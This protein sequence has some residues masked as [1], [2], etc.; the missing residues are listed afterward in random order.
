MA[1]K[2]AK[3]GFIRREF[4]LFSVVQV[5]AASVVVVVCGDD[6]GYDSKVACECYSLAVIIIKWLCSSANRKRAVL[7]TGKIM[8]SWLVSAVFKVNQREL[9]FNLC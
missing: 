2:Q 1:N 3:P 5:A 8:L 7:T 4:L 6:G 9:W